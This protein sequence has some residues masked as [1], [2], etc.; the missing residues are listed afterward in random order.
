MVHFKEWT[1]SEFLKESGACAVLGVG[2]SLKHTPCRKYAPSPVTVL[3]F[4]YI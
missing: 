4:D 3:G 1:R 2:S